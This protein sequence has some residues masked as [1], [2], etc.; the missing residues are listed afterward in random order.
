[1]GAVLLLTGTALFVLGLGGALVRRSLLVTLIALELAALGAVVVLVGFAL[2]GGDEGGL[3]RAVVLLFVGV[4]HA[5]LG[6]S[7][8][9]AIFRRRGT[10]NLDE[11]RELEG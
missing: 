4:A 7:V 10:L 5:V 6:A 3:A 8:A 2:R 9:I 11:L 1:M